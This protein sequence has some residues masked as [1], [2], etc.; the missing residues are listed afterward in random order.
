MSRKSKVFEKILYNQL[1]DFMKDKFSNILNGFRK[2]YSA[3]EA[4]LIMIEKLK[5]AL[6][7]NMRVGAMFM[8]LSKAFDTLNHRLFVAKL[9]A[10]S[11]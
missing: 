4:L 5:R 3:Q 11:I 8:D 6:D 2:G 1:N 9:K 10:C 7:E